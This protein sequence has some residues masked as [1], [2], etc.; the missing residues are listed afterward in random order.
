MTVVRETLEELTFVVET[1]VRQLKH[2]WKRGVFTKVATLWKTP[3]SS[4]TAFNLAVSRILTEG[5]P[6]RA[7]RT[8][9]MEQQENL[10]LIVT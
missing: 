4:V 2:P 6:T 8:E 9:E 3:D 1:G 7:T 5:D 10:S